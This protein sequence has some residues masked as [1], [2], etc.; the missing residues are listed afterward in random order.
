MKYGILLPNG[1]TVARKISYSR[2]GFNA[3]VR[4]N[5]VDFGIEKLDENKKLEETLL[6]LTI[7]HSKLNS[8]Y[9]N[10]ISSKDESIWANYG[11]TKYTY[12]RSKYM[13]TIKNEFFDGAK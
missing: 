6:A 3:W 9:I 4:I 5:K 10:K 7:V 11:D 2:N 12:N 8:K 1:K 13:N